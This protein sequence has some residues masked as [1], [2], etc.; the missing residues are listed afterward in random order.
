LDDVPRV[1]HRNAAER[2]HALG[3]L[4]DQLILLVGVLVEQQMKL[5]KGR[6]RA[7]TND[8]SCTERKESACRRGFGSIAGRNRAAWRAR[9]D[10]KIADGTE[11]LDLHATLMQPRLAERGVS[12][13]DLGRRLG[14]HDG[15]TEHVNEIYFG[16]EAS[17]EQIG[18]FHCYALVPRSSIRRTFLVDYRDLQSGV[19]DGRQ[20]RYQLAQAREN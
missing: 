5:I 7:S 14:A 19:D 13:G 20:F 15:R 18:D 11:L 10:R 3:D 8:I 16:F 2:L 12:R 4:V 9:A 1:A 17:Y 6:P